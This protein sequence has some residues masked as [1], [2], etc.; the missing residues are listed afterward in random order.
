MTYLAQV[1]FEVNQA[2]INAREAADAK[3]SFEVVRATLRDSESLKTAA[4]YVVSTLLMPT[5][6]LDPLSLQ[7]FGALNGDY[8]VDCL[9]SAG[10]PTVTARYESRAGVLTLEYHHGG[11]V[12]SVRTADSRLELLNFL[13]T[14]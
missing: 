12:L 9:I 5:N 6:E 8:I 4:Y 2:I 7:T 13:A 14:C 11:D 10:G 1:P 3:F